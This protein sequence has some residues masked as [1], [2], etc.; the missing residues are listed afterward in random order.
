MILRGVAGG[1]D[2]VA[3]VGETVAFKMRGGGEEVEDGREE[4][5]TAV[6]EL[7]KEA[8]GLAGGEG[9]GDERKLQIGCDS[10]VSLH[11]TSSISRSNP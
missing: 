3:D 10:S 4:G 2:G 6:D 11:N 1:I 5:L 7:C 8:E 9:M